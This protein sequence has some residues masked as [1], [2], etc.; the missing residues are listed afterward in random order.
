V[1]L[2]ASLL[3]AA[4]IVMSLVMFAM[5]IN[6]ERTPHRLFRRLSTDLRLLGAF[7]VTFLLSF[8]VAG[9]GLALEG[10]W[11]AYALYTE[12]WA[13]ASILLLFLYAYRR[14]LRLISP[15][16]QLDI[17]AATASK[18][19]QAWARRAER[20]APLFISPKEANNLESNHDLPRLTYF[21][22]NQ[23]WTKEARDEI[24]QAVAFSRRYS[25]QGDYD[26]SLRSLSAIVYINASYLTA[27]GRTFFGNE[28]LFDNPLTTDG[29]INHT[30]EQVRQN[31]RIAISRADEI[32]IEQNLR[33]LAELTKLY[34]GIDYGAKHTSKIHAVISAGY[35]GDAV[36]SALP[37]GMVNVLMEGIQLMGGC[38]LTFMAHGRSGDGATLID[39]I[40]LL[41]AVCATKQ[42]FQPVTLT[43]ME[44]LRDLTMTVLQ[45]RPTQDTK[46]AEMLTSSAIF[47]ATAMCKGQEVQGTF[48]QNYHLA[49]YFGTSSASSF[50]AR[51]TNL[52]NAIIA[53]DD[54]SEAAQ[55]AIY[56][57]LEWTDEL[58]QGVK[59]LLLLSIE[60]RSQLAFDMIHWV[61]AV[62][63]VIF[64]LSKA[65]ACPERRRENLVSAGLDLVASLSW[66]ARDR[67]T[68]KFVENY[69]F[70]ETLFRIAVDA[71]IY[72]GEENSRQCDELLMNWTFDAGQH[73][74]GWAILERGTYALANLALMS[75]NEASA[76]LLK[77]E[78]QKRVAE[79]HIEHDLKSRAARSIRK[80]AISRGEKY[81]HS[82]I[83]G[84][85]NSLDRNSARKLL[86]ELADILS[87]PA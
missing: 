19:L 66:V 52:G 44:Q 65:M 24:S 39:E 73:Q 28:L 41:S 5:Q 64:A 71:R 40:K 74:V 15:I 56:N 22:A 6:V 59:V 30:L 8:L 23:H 26:V 49:P 62:A 9:V 83:E 36:R 18:H 3:G 25:E 1:T 13:T 7:A 31:I 54:K 16:D 33:A 84:M 63:K 27:K 43:G 79:G 32:Q 4:A 87:P 85:L 48:L 70:T 42:E 10:N 82:A 67:D 21:N 61:A 75:D 46:I 29:F 17:I 86:S 45:T 53:A 76:L 80:K 38:V 11:I 12:L 47:I 57:I 34:T 78:Y 55:N 58:D 77:H 50:A 51:L 69:Q 60:K 81:T 72:I 20:A 37:S 68:V 2:G 14:A 35:L